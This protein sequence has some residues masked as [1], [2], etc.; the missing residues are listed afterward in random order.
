LRERLR[1]LGSRLDR[2]PVSLVEK[3]RAAL[4]SLAGRLRTLSHRATLNRGYAIVR[5]EAGILRSAGS[6]TSGD[7]IDIELAD[8]GVAARVEETRS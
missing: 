6:V 8:G 5:T 3:K 1:A 4:E 2:A 7:A